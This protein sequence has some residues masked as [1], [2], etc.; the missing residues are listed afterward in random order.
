VARVASTR[1]KKV[2]GLNRPA[3]V[4]RPPAMSGD[5]VPTKGRHARPRQLERHVPYGHR[6]VFDDHRRPQP[7]ILPLFHV[8]GI[9]GAAR[10]AAGVDQQARASSRCCTGSA[11]PAAAPD[12]SSAVVTTARTGASNSK[13]LLDDEYLRSGVLELVGTP[14]QAPVSG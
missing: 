12:A 11:T 3:M 6:C 4:A 5:S 2:F 10:C 7:A 1:S 14:R 9:V 8:N 13:R